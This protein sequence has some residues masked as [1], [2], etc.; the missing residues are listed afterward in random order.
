LF[1]DST[2]TGGSVTMDL[3]NTSMGKDSSDKIFGKGKNT[4]GF[5]RLE[6][7]PC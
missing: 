2:G 1:N 7:K 4:Y 3:N 6:R 5:E